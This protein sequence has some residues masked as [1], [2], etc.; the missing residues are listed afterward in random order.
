MVEFDLRDKG[1]VMQ[2]GEV[3][4]TRN[5]RLVV[6]HAKGANQASIGCCNGVPDIE[7]EEGLAQ[8]VGIARKPVIELRVRYHELLVLEDRVGAKGIF[9]FDFNQIK[10]IAGLEEFA[11]FIDQDHTGHGHIED[12]RGQPRDA[13]KAF[14]RRRVEK[15]Q[16]PECLQALGLVCGKW[17]CGHCFNF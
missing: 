3:F 11:P 9:A 17:G 7:P 8:N 16:G 2:N 1:E 5:A 15:L 13:V 6:H 14:F 12:A 10:A 4:R